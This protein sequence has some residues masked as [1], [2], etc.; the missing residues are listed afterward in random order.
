MKMLRHHLNA[1]AS[2]SKCGP[3]PGSTDVPEE[4]V[5]NAQ[6]QDPCQIY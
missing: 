2:C 3:R 6:Q 4:L 1:T 5:T